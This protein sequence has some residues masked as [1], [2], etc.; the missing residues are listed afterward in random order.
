MLLVI[1]NGGIDLSVGSILGLV[2][3]RRRRAARGRAPRR[4]RQI[5]Y[6]PVWAVIVSSRS[7]SARS[8]ALSTASL[9]TRFKV[10]PFIA[11]LGTLYVARGVAL[12]ISNG[13]TYPNLGGTRSSATPAST[14]SASA[15]SLGLPTSIW[16]MVVFADR[17]HVPARANAFGRWLYASG[18][19]ER[20]AELVRRAGPPGQ[21]A[22]LHDL[23]RLRR[24]RRR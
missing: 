9:I 1:L 17:R 24:D 20:A 5:V 10:A 22:R 19:N 15:R 14:A 3:R 8:S 6:P 18:G 16:I 4:S 7:R 21:D 13:A 2:R 11:T 23:R 12:L